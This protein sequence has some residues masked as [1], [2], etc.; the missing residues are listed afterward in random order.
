MTPERFAK[1]TAVL[2]RRQPDL[3]VLAEDVH[4][5]HN[6]AAIIRT[7][8]AVGVMRVHA[9]SPGG[10][11]PRHRL[12]SAGTRK[13]V[14]TV[15]HRDVGE[16]VDELRTTGCSVVA[17]HL[18]PTAIDYRQYDYTRPTAILLGSELM[19]VSDRAAALVDQHLV[20]P[21][22][23]HV[24]SL[25]VSVA[26]ALLLYE[27]ARQREAAGLY[28]TGRIDAAART[29]LLFEWCY[30]AVARHCRSRGIPYPELDDS[31]FM[32][33]PGLAEALRAR[34]AAAGTAPRSGA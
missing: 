19:G 33:R 26:A 20:V 4:K 6:I 10:E 12:I 3:T 22:R 30:P 31:G 32:V 5:S 23:G 18:S 27:A 13:W 29:T 7:C 9:V 1:I 16:A 25:N 2:D 15:M 34:R 14:R 24:A 11:I 8:D 28:E 17:A 21:M